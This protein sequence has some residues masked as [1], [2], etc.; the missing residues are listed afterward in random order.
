MSDTTPSTHPEAQRDETR[1]EYVPPQVVVY[2]AE[3]LLEKLG[4]AKACA[5][6]IPF[7]PTGAHRQQTPDPS[8]HWT[9]G[10]YTHK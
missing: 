2:S 9:V 7:G 10:P 6:Y 4:P 1:P 5:S 8:E 3:E